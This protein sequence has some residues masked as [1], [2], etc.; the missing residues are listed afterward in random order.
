M[1]LSNM[2]EAL[3]SVLGVINQAWHHILAVLAFT[4]GVRRTRSTRYP[5]KKSSWATIDT[6]STITAAVATTTAT[7][8]KNTKKEEEE[9]EEKMGEVLVW[10][11]P[12]N[13]CQ[14]YQRIHLTLFLILHVGKG[15]HR[16]RYFISLKLLFLYFVSTS[17]MIFLDHQQ[18]Q[19]TM[20]LH[21]NSAA[22]VKFEED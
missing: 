20:C 10:V 16:L 19:V 7:K 6:V 2:R 18:R 12:G 11:N 22:T 21:E 15:Q 5:C 14:Q 1:H 13:S 9:K 4:K 17:R 8:S 3:D